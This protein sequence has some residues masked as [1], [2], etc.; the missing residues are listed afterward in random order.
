MK[1]KAVRPA[2]GALG[3]VLLFLAYFVTA[4]LG[5]LLDAVAGFATLVWPPSGIALAALLLFGTRLW[6]GV[7]VGAL[8]VNLVIGASLPVALGIALGNTL[9]AVAGSWLLRRIGRF[10]SRLEGI[11]DVKALVLL[12]GVA[13]TAISAA[14]GLLSLR[15]GGTVGPAMS[16]PTFRAWWFGDMLGDLVVAPLLLVWISRPTPPRRRFQAPEALLLG[17]LL[18][19][20]CLMVFGRGLG[21]TGLMR[22][23]YLIFPPLLWAA[24]RFAQ[25]GA[26]SA[27]F[28]ISAF[29]IAATTLGYG[30][31]VRGTLAE[32]L[33]HLQIFLAVGAATALTV[34]AAIAERSR[35]VDA[36]D[37]FLAIASHELRTPL[38]ALLLFIQ[39]E[40]RSLRREAPAE[41][42]DAIDRLETTHRVALRLE[43]LIAELLE[44]S[45]IIWCRLEP[46][47]EDVDLVVLVRDSLL[48]QQQQLLNARCQVH[49]EVEGAVRGN[50]DRGRLDRVLDNLIGNAVK[51]GAG[52]PIEVRLHGGK[53]HVRLEVRDH[54]IGIDPADQARVFERFERA[55]SRRQYGGFG[56]G[57]WIS[58]KIVEAHGGNIS[59]MSEPGAGCTFSVEL[60]RSATPVS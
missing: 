44:V 33:L 34:A 28:V 25:Y 24:L 18:I 49:L 1:R 12:G 36:R 37:E 29:A 14:V 15:L 30:P 32:S 35:A 21:D 16:W 52:K 8:C 27:T 22:L 41:R 47:R 45:R 17:G 42:K 13:S 26:V 59:L 46:E 38:T 57:L 48:R 3:I 6:P 43:K 2:R 23:P 51:Y 31:F 50:W 56:L 4:R 54:G 20:C 53:E 40:L 9:E 60:P 5:L 10:D 58:R 11:D 55:V 7:L 39:T 19:G